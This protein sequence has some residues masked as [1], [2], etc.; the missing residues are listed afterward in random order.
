MTE[1]D[2]ALANI[3]KFII[4]CPVVFDWVNYKG[5]DVFGVL[6]YE[7][8]VKAKRPMI[9]ICYCATKAMDNNVMETV[10]YNKKHFKP[11]KLAITSDKN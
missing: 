6:N 10:Q 7:R 8:S 3:P 11:S 9:D 5:E 2:K 1:F 4:D